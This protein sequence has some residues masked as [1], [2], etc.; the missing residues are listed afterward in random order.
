MWEEMKQSV[1]ECMRNLGIYVDDAGDNLLIGDYI[2]DSVMF[3]SFIVE[4]EQT[5]DVQ[6]PDDYLNPGKLSTLDEVCRLIQG[7]KISERR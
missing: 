1:L 7:L 5:F 6:I 3:I 4:L 2:E